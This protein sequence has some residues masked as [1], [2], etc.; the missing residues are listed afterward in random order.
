MK[1]STTLLLASPG[2]WPTKAQL[3]KSSTLLW[4]AIPWGDFF[5][6]SERD[7]TGLGFEFFQY[8]RTGFIPGSDSSK[9][10]PLDVDQRKPMF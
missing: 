5:G 10:S 7:L 3:M 2:C 8:N 4:L 1:S 9:K 6:A